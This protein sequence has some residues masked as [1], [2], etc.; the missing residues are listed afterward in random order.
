MSESIHTTNMNVVNK[1][2]M[3]ENDLTKTTAAGGT[4]APQVVH[5]AGGQDETG[6]PDSFG[7]RGRKRRGRA[8]ADSDPRCRICL[9]D[10]GR[11][12]LS[13]FLL[14]HLNKQCKV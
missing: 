1:G 3:T 4:V 5:H 13:V 11:S 9:F 14:K 8:N 10:A 12:L 7:R 6:T 2:K